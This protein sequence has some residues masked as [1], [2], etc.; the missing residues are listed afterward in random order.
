MTVYDDKLT[1][2]DHEIALVVV[3]DAEHDSLQRGLEL[4][5]L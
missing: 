1:R 5:V 2:P 4:F 3:E